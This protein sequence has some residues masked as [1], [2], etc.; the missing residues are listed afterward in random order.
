[1]GPGKPNQQS[2][3]LSRGAGVFQEGT[4]FTA[5]VQ[6]RNNLGKGFGSLSRLPAWGPVFRGGEEGCTPPKSLTGH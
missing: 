3:G 1:M 4:R 5:G 2:E 6:G